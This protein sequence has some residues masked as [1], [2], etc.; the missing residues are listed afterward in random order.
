MLHFVVQ[1]GAWRFNCCY[2]YYCRYYCYYCCYYYYC[3]CWFSAFFPVSHLHRHH[4]TS[5]I[6]IITQA[7]LSQD[8]ERLQAQLQAVIQVKRAHHTCDPNLQ[9]IV[10]DN[11][12]LSP[13]LPASTRHRR[14]D[15]SPTRILH[16]VYSISGKTPKLRKHK[17]PKHMNPKPRSLNTTSAITPPCILAA[18]NTTHASLHTSPTPTTRVTHRQQEAMQSQLQVA[19]HQNPQTQPP[20]TLNLLTKVVHNHNS[21]CHT[22][23][24]VI[25][26]RDPCKHAEPSSIQSNIARLIV[27]APSVDAYVLSRRLCQFARAK[28]TRSIRHSEGS[29]R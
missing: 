23:P 22:L 17:Q 5:R 21:N 24:R 3:C 4:R 18:I 20:S 14:S 27:F 16:C 12:P 9:R 13:L 7:A 25:N 19:P 10:R 2:C 11:S 1:F 8:A 6:I 28:L 26:T 29:S 15:E